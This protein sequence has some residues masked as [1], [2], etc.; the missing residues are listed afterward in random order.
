MVIQTGCTPVIC[1]N[2]HR[3]LGGKRAVLAPLSV[4][5]LTPD[6]NATAGISSG[7]FFL[8]SMIEREGI[9]WRVAIAT[10]LPP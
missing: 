9:H 1:S 4:N 5:L 6:L 7:V 3:L 10:G 2:K 8:P